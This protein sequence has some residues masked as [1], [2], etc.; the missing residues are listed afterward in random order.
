MDDLIPSMFAAAVGFAFV[1][2]MISWVVDAKPRNPNPADA[3]D[4]ATR[5]LTGGAP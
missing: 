3:D 4:V 1:A 2:L 5:I